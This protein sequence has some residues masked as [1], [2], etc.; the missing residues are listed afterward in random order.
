MSSDRDNSFHSWN[1]STFP[2][3]KGQFAASWWLIPMASKQHLEHPKTWPRVRLGL[4]QPFLFPGMLGKCL[5]SVGLEAVN[6]MVSSC[7]FQPL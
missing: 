4:R 1:R 6:A 7:F 5:G 3:G 2:I